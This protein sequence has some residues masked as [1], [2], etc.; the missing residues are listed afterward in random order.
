M[1]KDL[2]FLFRQLTHG[3]Y[4]VGV[5]PGN[6]VNA[7]TAAWVMQ[8]SFNPLLLAL[9]ISPRHSSY[10]SLIEGG[11]FTVNV[12]PGN[13]MDLAEHFGQPAGSNKL[14]DVGWH[15]CNTGA[16]VLDDAM[17]CFECEFSHECRAGDHMLV[18]GRVTGGAVLDP[19]AIPMIYRD[20]GD[21]DGSSRLFPEDFN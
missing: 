6:D 10:K 13:R 2:Y 14:A 7:F 9:S 1:N 11:S 4:V 18:V 17:A 12:L 20:T 8:V 5:P 3:V 16:P 15:R 21:M 19:N